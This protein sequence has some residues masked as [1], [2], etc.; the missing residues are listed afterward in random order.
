[1]VSG[2]D[3]FLDYK[4]LSRRHQP[5]PPNAPSDPVID[6]YSQSSAIDDWAFGA[7]VVAVASSEGAVQ[8]SSPS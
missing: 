7:G 3:R 1:M 6:R 4:G 2:V 8:D 5:R